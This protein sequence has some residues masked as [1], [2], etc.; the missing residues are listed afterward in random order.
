MT[1]EARRPG[2]TPE[3][4]AAPEYRRLADHLRQQI[5]DGAWQPGEPLPTD[6]E[7]GE[8]FSVSRQTVRRAY[9]DLVNAGIVVREPGRGTFLA[10]PRMRYHRTFETVDD[11]IGQSEDSSLEIVEPLEGR[12]VADAAQRLQL[13]HRLMYT[14][15]FLRLHRGEP[16]GYTTVYLPAEVGMQLE[17]V[18][19]FSMPGERTAATVIGCLEQRGVHLESAEQSITARAADA[20]D[21]ELLGCALDAP[22]LAVER[23]YH[24]EGGQLIELARSSF[25]PEKYTHHTALH[26]RA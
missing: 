15:R 18:E 5:K 16:F 19:A 6:A 8:Q 7:L 20:L 10:P 9:M 24:G 25:L 3:H 17:G 14:M 4:R 2:T 21:A 26:R 1:T 22:I 12:Y 13:Q 11:L 23:L